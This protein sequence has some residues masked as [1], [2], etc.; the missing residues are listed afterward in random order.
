[1]EE[2]AKELSIIKQFYIKIECVL[3]IIYITLNVRQHNK[4]K[5]NNPLSDCTHIVIVIVYCID[6]VI[7]RKDLTAS[8]M[9]LVIK[10]KKKV[11]GKGFN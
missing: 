4:Q 5:L 11:W 1:M 10:N 7:L 3:Y 8:L 9:L 2:N 6:N